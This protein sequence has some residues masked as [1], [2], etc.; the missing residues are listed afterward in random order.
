[1]VFAQWRGRRAIEK[2]TYREEGTSN[3]LSPFLFGPFTRL[4]SLSRHSDTH[5]TKSILNYQFHSKLLYYCL[6]YT[7]HFVPSAPTLVTLSFDQV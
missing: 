2:G 7:R 5:N 1:M 3:S 6:V 4:N